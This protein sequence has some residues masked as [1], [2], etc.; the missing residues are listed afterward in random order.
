MHEKVEI[1]KPIVLKTESIE[2]RLQ[3]NKKSAWTKG[4]HHLKRSGV[5]REPDRI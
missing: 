1:E 4:H 2:I 3:G 5:L